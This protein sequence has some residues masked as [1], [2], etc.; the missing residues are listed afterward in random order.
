MEST[1]WR[2]TIRRLLRMITLDHGAMPVSNRAAGRNVGQSPYLPNQASCNPSIGQRKL[3]S[4][5]ALYAALALALHFSHTLSTANL[6]RL[7]VFASTHEPCTVRV[8]AVS[9]LARL[10]SLARH[11]FHIWPTSTR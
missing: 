5:D 11:P 1:T 10:P 7:P 8:C 3:P 9:P 4:L 6:H 2:F